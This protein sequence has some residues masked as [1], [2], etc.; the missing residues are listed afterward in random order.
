MYRV[1]TVILVSI[2]ALATRVSMPS[3]RQ[4]TP[5]PEITPFV[6]PVTAPNGVSAPEGGAQPGD[7]GN[8]ALWTNLAMWAEEPG[9]VEVPRD[10]HLLPD[11]RVVGLKW[12]WW[13]FV[14]GELTIEGRRL[15]APAPPLEAWMP[16]GY[17]SSGF[18]VSGLTFPTDGCWE[19]TGSLGDAGSLTFV[20]KVVY[21]AG[22]VPVADRTLPDCPVTQ[23][24]GNQPPAEANVFGRG[25]GD[26]GNDALW[27]SLW[28]WGQG[29]VFAPDDAHLRPDGRVVE[30]K[31][32]WYRYVA[33]TLTIEGRPLDAPA[34][35]LEAWIPDGYGDAGFQVSGITFPTDGCWEITGHLGEGSLTFV[36]QVVYP[37]SFTPVAI[38]EA[39]A[40]PERL[41]WVVRGR[42][43]YANGDPKVLGT[44][45]QRHGADW[46]LPFQHADCPLRAV[47]HQEGSSRI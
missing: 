26:Y 29:F 1:V 10:G 28:V 46:P 33:G 40:T 34:P 31:W 24:N 19:V 30:M 4:G 38:P 25:N 22:F 36:V 35:P 12:A 14:E 45:S 43:R 44:R 11:G 37:P 5:E 32:P 23:P 2:M 6:C 42:A 18:Q 20:V 21:P 15:D 41:P 17:G 3:A 7:Y 39:P 9:I 16:E 27:T 13:R 8:E 47:A